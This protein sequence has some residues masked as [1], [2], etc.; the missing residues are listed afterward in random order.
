MTLKQKDAKIKIYHKIQ[1]PKKDLH[2]KG[3][4][5]T[6]KNISNYEKWCEHWR[7]KFLQTDLTDLKIR[8]PE[9][10]DHGE[11]LSIF[12]FGKQYYISK[13]TGV[14]TESGSE[15]PVPTFIR[16][17]IYTLFE[18]A[19]PHTYFFNQWVPFEQLKGARPFAPAFQKHCI[20]TF[21]AIFSGHLKELE[22]AFLNLGGTKLPY[23]DMG[24][25]I[26][27]FSCIPVQFLFWD[28]DEEF[29]AQA[30][31]LFDKSAV[32]FIHVESIVTISSIGIQRLCEESGVTLSKASFLV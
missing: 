2:R 26:H 13:K 11:Q 16:L 18:Y 15:T 22:N 3:T 23:S 25:Q 4:N 10:K 5:M 14:I 28:K 27:A 24:Y 32:N 12:H 29:P 8:I 21:A 20:E 17:N 30:N 31:I 6:Q 7:Q 1:I 19:K 9:L